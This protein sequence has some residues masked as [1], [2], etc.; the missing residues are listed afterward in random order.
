[1]LF[2]TRPAWAEPASETTTEPRAGARDVVHLR[3]GVTIEGSVREL[4]P[5]DHVTVVVDG[6]DQRF[7]WADVERV[8]VSERLAAPREGARSK[9]MNGPLVRVHLTGT[10]TLHLHRRPEGSQDFVEVCE[11]P[12]DVEVPLQDTFKVSGGSITTTKEFRLAG[13]PGSMVTVEVDGPNWFG[14]VGG[15]V[16][17]IVGGV[18]AYVGLA[19]GTTPDTSAR[20]V[21]LGA[22]MIGGATLA[23]GLLI[24]YPSMRTD[25]LQHG[26]DRGRDAY[27]RDPSWTTFARSH[28]AETSL[29]PRATF[30]ILFE[31]SF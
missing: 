27:R 2:V 23:L 18:T 20:G 15:G 26:A 16:L 17:T 7:L 19:L 21:G 28:T 11:S 24:V 31:R 29:A 5:G 10:G 30:P 6:A 3:S 14:I 13:T 4:V 1:M 12:C 25:L 8:V 22:L 9:P